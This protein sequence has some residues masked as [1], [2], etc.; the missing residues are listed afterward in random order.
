M[1]VFY[2]MVLLWLVLPASLLV[3]GWVIAEVIWAFTKPPYWK[4]RDWRA[5][6][7]TAVDRQ[8]IEQLSP[9]ESPFTAFLKELDKN[10]ETK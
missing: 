8:L 5:P 6:T 7:F 2:V 1:D 10:K 3:L 4:L 9:T